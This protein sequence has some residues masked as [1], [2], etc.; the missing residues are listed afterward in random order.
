MLLV[1]I[2]A[3]TIVIVAIVMVDVVSSL[4]CICFFVYFVRG[5]RKEKAHFVKKLVTKAINYVPKSVV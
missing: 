4:L 3:I 1:I 5:R 2:A